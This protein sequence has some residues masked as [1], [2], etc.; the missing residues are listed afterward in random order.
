MPPRENGQDQP[1]I[2]DNRKIDPE[3]GQ[4]REATAAEQ[5]A[6]QAPAAAEAPGAHGELAAQLAE[7]TADLQRLQ[8]EY[9]NYRKRVERDR[10]VVREQAVAGALTELLPV[11][12]DI[13]RARDHGELTGGFAKVA[14]SLESVLTKLGLSAFGQKGDPF[15]P[16]VHEALMHSYSEDVTE[17]TAIE[18]LQPG[19]RLGDRVLRPARVAVAEPGD[20][21]PASNDDEN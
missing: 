6:E 11:L 10:A 4:V 2:R 15:D 3:T 12:D 7:R 1:V 18:V 16:T 5:E 21:T 8:A 20:A 14:E 19:Y 13:G 17:P 9:V